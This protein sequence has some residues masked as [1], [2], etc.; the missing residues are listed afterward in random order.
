[1]TTRPRILEAPRI[2]PQTYAVRATARASNGLTLA[3]LA[4]D[5]AFGHPAQRLSIPR[6][7]GGT[8]HGWLVPWKDLRLVRVTILSALRVAGAWSAGD[9]VTV[10]LSITDG[11]TT[12]TSAPAIPDDFGTMLLPRID[13]PWRIGTVHPEF[14]PIT[15]IAERISSRAEAIKHDFIDFLDNLKAL[16]P[17]RREAV[18]RAWNT[19]TREE[20]EEAKR[21]TPQDIFKQEYEAQFLEDS[22]GVFRNLE[23]CLL[24]GQPVGN[25][26]WVA[27]AWCLGILVVAY[28]CAMRIY[29]RRTA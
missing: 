6:T 26:I 18:T 3:E 22:A 11:T 10:A 29:R 14:R 28:A 20:W 16:S 7:T 17:D 5:A 15:D 23:A 1:M 9:G 27:L 12:V 2:D 25:D 13:S 21:T 19:G 8:F 4:N 24:A